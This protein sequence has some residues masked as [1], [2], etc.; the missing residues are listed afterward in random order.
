MQGWDS[1]GVGTWFD[2]PLLLIPSPGPVAI[3]PAGLNDT[4]TV[5]ALTFLVPSDL[6]LE[7]HVPG[8]NVVSGLFTASTAVGC[9]VDPEQPWPAPPAGAAAHPLMAC[10]SLCVCVCPCPTAP[11]ASLCPQHR[12][13][14]P[15]GQSEELQPLSQRHPFLPHLGLASRPN[16]DW[17]Q[18]CL[19]CDRAARGGTAV[20]FFP[21]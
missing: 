10:L 19:T 17:S 1:G 4:A 20:C 2:P 9:G 7:L 16:G 13:G 8:Q 3:G 14:A 15:L 12:T 21:Y 18:P 11:E 6:T 5:P